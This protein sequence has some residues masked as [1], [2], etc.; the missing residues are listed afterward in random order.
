MIRPIGSSFA[1]VC[2]AIA[3]YARAQPLPSI[4]IPAYLVEEVCL[5]HAGRALPIDPYSC[6]YGDTLRPVEIGEPLPYHKHDQPGPDYP[7]GYQQHDS[8]PARDLGG[9]VLI[10]NPFDY[11]PFDRFKSWEDGYDIYRLKDGWVS[12]GETEDGGGFSTTF[13]GANCMPY[14]GWVFFPA[15]VLEMPA[16][17]RVEMPIHGVYWE[18]NGESWPGAC[19]SSYQTHSL[20]TWDFIKDFPFGGIGGNPVKRLDA[21]RSIHGFSTNPQFLAHGHLEVFYFT[22]LYGVT[23]WEVWTPRER[24]DADD[25]LRQRAEEVAMRC[26]GTDDVGYEGQQFVVTACRD[27]S[28]VTV[29]TSPSAPTAWPV[30][31][32][33]LLRNFHFGD[34]FSG[35]KYS[36]S[37][38]GD[39]AMS[40]KNSTAARDTRF[41]QPGGQGVRYVALT[42]LEKCS[43]A[44]IFYQD[45][46]MTAN[47]TSGTY[48]FG[49]TARFEGNG[50][51]A[52]EFILSQLDSS[53]NVLS[54]KSFVANV[55][56]SNG[57]FM[58]TDSIVLSSSFESLTAPVRIGQ[59]TKV[60]RFG[61]SPSTIGIFDIVDTWVIKDGS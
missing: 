30:P 37:N 42:C 32:L 31:D 59:A 55:K 35:W 43:T 27:W 23:R 40:L 46:P 22:K 20:T 45:V 41:V 11:E 36:G 21:I 56:P 52:L 16:P 13:F 1:L 15:S 38:P 9:D 33:N 4:S 5:S 54:E 50:T 6:P 26:K 12:G 7:D 24:V 57:H 19:P 28:A 49:A 48:T 10:V 53:G 18:Q 2:A 34:G 29:S 58:D 14:N 44:N 8:Y 61:I 17:G 3:T 51:G 39:I 60:L 25:Q 47:I